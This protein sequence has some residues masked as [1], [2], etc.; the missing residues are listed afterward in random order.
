MIAKLRTN[1]HGLFI[2]LLDMPS[3]FSRWPYLPSLCYKKSRGLL[4][5]VAESN[6]SDRRVFRG[7][8]QIVAWTNPTLEST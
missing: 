6:E 2:I 1:D 3:L 5:R 4:S 8:W 7:S